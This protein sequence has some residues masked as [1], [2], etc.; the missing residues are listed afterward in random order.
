M[1][2]PQF[3]ATMHFGLKRVDMTGPDPCTIDR[4]GQWSEERWERELARSRRRD[5][6]VV[7]LIAIVALV[8]LVVVGAFTHP[9]LGIGTAAFIF[10]ALL[11]WLLPV[12]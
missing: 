1:D 12:S 8:S 9:L 4:S 5:I 11:T 7:V 2:E 10:G 3:K 6:G